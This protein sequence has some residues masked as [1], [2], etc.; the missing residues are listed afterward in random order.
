M[1]INFTFSINFFSLC[2]HMAFAILYNINVHK[3][4]KKLS[5]NYCYI[6]YHLNGEQNW[7]TGSGQGFVQSILTPSHT[8]VYSIPYVYIFLYIYTKKFSSPT[9]MKKKT[10]KGMNR[11][12]YLLFYLWTWLEMKSGSDGPTKIFDKHDSGL[13]LIT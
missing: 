11:V 8:I 2:T 1:K 12:Y 9:K 10:G 7:P 6:L 13:I 4:G 3:S 5:P